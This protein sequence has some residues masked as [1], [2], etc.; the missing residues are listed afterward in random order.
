MDQL[1]YGA[2]LSRRGGPHHRGIDGT[3][4]SLGARIMRREDRAGQRNIRYVAPIG[5]GSGI[6]GA[7]GP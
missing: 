3:L 6:E 2:G 5:V 4:A 7:R 1:G